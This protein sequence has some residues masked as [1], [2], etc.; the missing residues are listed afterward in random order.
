MN[1]TIRSPMCLKPFG[2]IS[3]RYYEANLY[4]IRPTMSA[5]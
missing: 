3:E 1:P 2:E 4:G 5:Y